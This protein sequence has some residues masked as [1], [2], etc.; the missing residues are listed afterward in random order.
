MTDSRDRGTR[1]T[2]KAAEKEK[3]MIYLSKTQSNATS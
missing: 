1:S 2:K 3:K